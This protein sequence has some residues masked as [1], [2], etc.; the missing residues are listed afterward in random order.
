M[1]K[2]GRVEGGCAEKSIEQLLELLLLRSDHAFSTS[3][4]PSAFS[5]S[6]LFS[7]TAL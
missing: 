2:P 6:L 4:S 3:R 5:T 7:L 1:E